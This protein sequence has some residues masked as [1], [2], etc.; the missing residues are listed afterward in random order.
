MI[1]MHEAPEKKYTFVTHHR[2]HIDDICG[3]WQFLRFLP[4]GRGAEVRFVSSKKPDSGLPEEIW[5]GVGRGRF[6][7]HKGDLGESAATLVFKYLRAEQADLAKVDLD[8]LT[9]LVTWIRDEDTGLH[10]DEYDREFGIMSML[11]SHYDRHGRDSSELLRFGLEIL[12]NV[13]ESLKNSARLAL[14]WEKR[15][16]FESPWGRA[17]GL[18]TGSYGADDFAYQKGFMLVVIE[19]TV[20][21]FR[22]FR[23]A[24]KSNVD[25]SSAYETLR[26]VDPKADWYL[27]HS[28]KLL[29]C[30]SDVAP[31]SRKSNLSLKDLIRVLTP[32]PESD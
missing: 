4:E 31:D 8:A 26:R 18:V 9:R 7:E 3:V 2:P 25:L 14:D 13:Y 5:I 29:L 22:G 1:S 21:G 10:D 23:A 28:R 16:D 20:R 30:G 27:H 15:I 17:V 6:D 12:D 24:A 32:L 19:D 11:R